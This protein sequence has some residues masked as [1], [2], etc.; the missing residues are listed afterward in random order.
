MGRKIRAID[1]TTGKPIEIDEDRIKSG[2]VRQPSLPDP[3]LARVRVVH[4]RIKPVY[5]VT[6]EQFELTFMRDGDPE[7]EVAIW[8]ALASKLEQ[9]AAEMSDVDQKMI[10]RTLLAY[11]M[12]ALT[13]EERRD[14]TVKRIIEAAERE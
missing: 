10:L 9:A 8:E 5:D 7:G 6:L 11:S 13:P 12:D 2:P 3:L 14:T 4:Q 1:A